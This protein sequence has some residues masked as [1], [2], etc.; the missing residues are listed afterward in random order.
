MEQKQSKIE[1]ET[2]PG[3]T[4]R[5]GDTYR[6]VKARDPPLGLGWR[7]SLAKASSNRP[8][9]A[10]IVLWFLVSLLVQNQWQSAGDKQARRVHWAVEAAP[11]VTSASLRPA[12]NSG[13]HAA[14]KR[15][16]PRHLVAYLR[17]PMPWED[18]YF[19]P[20][21]H[22]WP[23]AGS[24]GNKQQTGDG[25]ASSSSA[26]VRKRSVGERAAH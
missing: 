25:A 8:L 15:R 5:G 9:F 16:A 21:Y 20:S 1:T 7:L 17:E 12:L 11:M 18:G 2:R 13:P 10:T 23:K 4:Q 26:G 6:G 24:S 22:A 14:W 19:D 3:D